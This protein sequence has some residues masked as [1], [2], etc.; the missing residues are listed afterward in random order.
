MCEGQNLLP[1]GESDLPNAGKVKLWCP[2]CEDLYN[3][4]SAR[5]AAIDGAYF[6]TSF[7]GMLFQV[8][9][10]LMPEKSIRRYE[11]RVYGFRVHASAALARWQD[12]FREE[13]KDRLKESGVDVKYAEDSDDEEREEM[14]DES[15]EFDSKTVKA[16]GHPAAE[17]QGEKVLGDGA[18]GQMDVGN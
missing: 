14:S 10:A 17:A 18:S 15:D 5:H 6:G 7:H 8:Y 4:K 3:P 9:P 13:T 11:P 12:S 2:K 16:E 1:T